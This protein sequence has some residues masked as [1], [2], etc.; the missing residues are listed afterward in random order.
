M[1]NATDNAAGNAMRN[2]NAVSQGQTQV[3]FRVFVRRAATGSPSL[4]QSQ[5][6][7][8]PAKSPPAIAPG[9]AALW[10]C[11]CVWGISFPTAPVQGSIPTLCQ[12][13]IQVIRFVLPQELRP[14][15]RGGGQ[16]DPQLLQQLCRCSRPRSPTRRKLLLGSSSTSNDQQLG[17]VDN[18]TAPPPTT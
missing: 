14:T 12:S 2:G 8:T 1:R 7:I 18:T 16:R 13:A 5:V 15:T 17:V 11:H 3:I 9:A 10:G 4:L 6:A